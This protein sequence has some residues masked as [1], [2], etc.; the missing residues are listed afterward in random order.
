MELRPEEYNP[1]E[2]RHQPD[3]LRPI[4]HV[5]TKT[6]LK[7]EWLQGQAVPVLFGLLLS[8]FPC[9]WCGGLIPVFGVRLILSLDGWLDDAF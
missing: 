3:T 5:L 7:P 2:Q 1:Q 9:C 8:R 6:E 4:V